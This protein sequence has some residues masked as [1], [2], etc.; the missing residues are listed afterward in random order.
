[1][2]IVDILLGLMVVI[3]WGI[4]FSAI[5]FGLEYMPPLFFSAMRF[6]IVA[7]PAILFVSFPKPYWKEV[8]GVGICLGILK[9]G[10]LFFAIKSGAPPGLSSLLIQSH[11]FITI[12][13][14]AIF[15]K[16]KITKRQFIGLLLSIIGITGL[17]FSHQNERISATLLLVLLAA[18]FWACSNAI[19]KRLKNVNILH[20]TIW[21]SV[22]PPIPLFILSALIEPW[23][24]ITFSSMFNIES[25]LS[26]AYVGYLST[27]VA[28]SIWGHLLQ[29]YSAITVS[30]LILLVPVVGMLAAFFTFGENI[31]FF[32]LIYIVLIL[33][34]LVTCI[35]PFDL[36]KWIIKFNLF[37]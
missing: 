36:K 13:F 30:P 11:V 26:L 34:G 24:S 16:E 14:S 9:F 27:L 15:W 12:L 19:M 28:F 21:V 10:L 1:M 29:K 20:F 2:K 6:S 37:K 7:I 23:E 17:A 25:A 4:N 22:I 5:K 33:I 32:E 18:F 3:I 31:N 8:I 35:T